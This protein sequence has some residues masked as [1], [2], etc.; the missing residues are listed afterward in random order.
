L[1]DDKQAPLPGDEDRWLEE[2]DPL[3]RMVEQEAHRI[4]TEAH[5]EPDPAL[6]AQGW[7]RRFMGDAGRV[8]EAVQLYEEMGYE[9]LTQPVQPAELSDD[10]DGCRLV[11][12]FQFQTIYT[13]RP[14][15]G[16]GDTD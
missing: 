3:S 14:Q 12:A 6:V 9:V 5:L 10:C 8:K 4:L 15:A 1:P 16:M 2:V 7:E 11:V 13:R